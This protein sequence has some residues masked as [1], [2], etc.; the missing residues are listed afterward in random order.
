MFTLHDSFF[1]SSVLELPRVRHAFSTRLGGIS[2]DSA[3]R[4]MNV[5]PGHGDTP[6][7]I[8]ENISILAGRVGVRAEDTVCTHQIHSSLVCYAGD[9][10][11]GRGVVSENPE[12]CDGFYTDVPGVALMVRTADCAPILLGGLRADG[13]PA[14]CALH[15]G[16]RG[17]CAAIAWYGCAALGCLG[18]EA[19]DIFAAVGP[20]AHAERFEV[21]EDMRDTAASSM[22][23]DF[24]RRSAFRRCSGNEPRGASHVGSPRESHRHLRPLYDI[25]AGA[26]PFPPRDR[27]TARSDGQHYRNIADGR[28][29]K[30]YRKEG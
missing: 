20:C 7:Q 27:R 10:M 25:G 11:R 21:G 12:E 2:T 15:A 16:W 1:T 23:A 4:S 5:A 17:S 28:K 9:G 6:E 18:V 24:A 22:G 19:A 13:T 8:Y 29:I 26:V 3:T 30:S 14:V